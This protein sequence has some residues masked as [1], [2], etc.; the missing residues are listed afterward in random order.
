MTTAAG[1]DR[2]AL[3]GGSAVASSNVP[4]IAVKLGDDEIEAAVGVLRGG[5]LAQG[6]NVAEFQTAFAE[7]TGARHALACSNGTCALQLAYGAIGLKAGDRVLCPSWTYIA[8]ASML[9]AVGAEI[10]WV[11]ADPETYTVD[12]EDLKKKAD[13]TIK[14]IAATHIYGTPAHVRA[15]DG[16]GKELGVPVI[17][18][19]AQAHLA[20]MEGEGLGA[21]GDIVTYSFY[22]TKN[23]TTAEGGMVTTNDDDLA[24]R[25]ALL[26][27]HGET[28]KYTHTHIGFNYRMSDV[29]AA[30]GRV[31]LT[32]LPEATARRRA[33][34]ARYTEV[35]EG[36]AGLHAPGVPAGAESAYHLYAVRVDPEVLVSPEEAGHAGL[37]LRELVI[38]ALNAEGVGTAVHYPKSLTRQPVFDEPGVD[39]QP[40]SDRLAEELVC[41]P[42]HQHLTDEQVEQVCEALVK[43]GTALAR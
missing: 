18:D 10:V 8:T 11:D 16:L 12:V 9:A 41:V 6:K 23:M 1:M 20:T 13:G 24:G 33:N 15:I 38:K 5:M 35:L 21:F 19:A 36:V 27:S 39:H 26:R 29:S 25:I 4:M 37:S 32:K 28:E 22:P 7:A 14:A 43:V 3:N 2:L 17:Y 31:Q 34:A 42:V 30:I 40:V